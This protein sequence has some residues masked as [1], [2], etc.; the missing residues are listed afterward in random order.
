MN[1]NVHIRQKIPNWLSL[2]LAV[3]F[4]AQPNQKSEAKTKTPK[5]KSG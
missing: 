2:A 4:A 3:L 1:S 5:K